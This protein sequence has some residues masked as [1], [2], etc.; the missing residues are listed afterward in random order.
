MLRQTKMVRVLEDV[1]DRFRL[2]CAKRKVTIQAAV[3]EAIQDKLIEWDAEDEWQKLRAQAQAQDTVQDPTED[4]WRAGQ[5]TQ[6][7]QSQDP[8]D[9]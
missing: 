3:T 6:A 7:A 1:H 4:D 8:A 9:A 2:A 5:W